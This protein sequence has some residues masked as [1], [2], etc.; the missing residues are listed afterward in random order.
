MVKRVINCVLLGGLALLF[1][2]K[3][4]SSKNHGPII[5]GDSSAIVT[6]TDTSK[7]QDGVADYNPVIKPSEPKDTPA[8][9]PATAAAPPKKADTPR[10]NPLLSIP[11]VQPAAALSGPGLKADF[12]IMTAL[13]PNLNAKQSGKAD[14]S[15][16]NGAVYTFIS[17]MLNGNVL[18]VTANVTKVSQRYQS[19]VVLKNEMGMLP[20]ETLTTTTEWQTLKGSGNIYKLSGLDDKSLD[21]PE[22]N[23][24][25]I[26]N[27]VAKAA[28]RHHMSKKKIQQWVASVHN[29][30]SVTQKPLCVMLRS[31]MWKIDG[32][33]ASGKPFSKQIRLD[34][35]M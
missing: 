21:Y 18:R 6:E 19:I 26:A 33:D 34:F 25:T 5:L 22:A 24:G 17:G 11:H 15:K 4:G 30:H 16:A 14:L 23:K 10:K 9:A 2:C 27:A 29:A 28:Q 35:P 32:K 13:I 8:V 12:N 1:S 31:V 7:L 3:G 20:L